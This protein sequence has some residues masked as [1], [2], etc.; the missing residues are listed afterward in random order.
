M[1]NDRKEPKETVE[2]ARGCRN[3][4]SFERLQELATSLLWSGAL[5]HG[6]KTG[7]RS[8]MRGRRT[9]ETLC[10]ASLDVQ[11]A[12]AVAKTRVD[13][14]TLQVDG[15]TRMDHRGAAGGGEGPEGGG[16]CRVA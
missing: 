10:W 13:C 15:G 1:L 12:S 5:V 4:V 9:C 11:T 8:A 3:G 7:W 14:G 6:R 2:A 16:K